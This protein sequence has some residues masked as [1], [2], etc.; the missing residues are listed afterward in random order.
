MVKSYLRYSQGAC[1]G[2]ITSGGSNVQF[3]GSGALGIAPALADV[4]VW[5]LKTGAH[6]TTLHDKNVQAEVT[7]LCRSP[8]GKRVA[9]GYD[10]GSIRLWELGTSKCEAI[11]HGH[12]KSVTVLKYNE[13]GNLLASGSKDTDIVVWDVIAEAGQCRLRGHKDAITDLIFLDRGM[14][15]LVFSCS[16]DTLAKVWEL[17][18][19]QCIQTLVG[20]RNEIWSVDANSE[21]TRIVTAGKDAEIRVWTWDDSKAA[22]TGSTPPELICL[23]SLQRTSR[24]RVVTVRF[25]RLNID[26]LAVQSADKTVEIFKGRDAQQVTKKVKRKLKRKRE[27]EKAKQARSGGSDGTEMDEDDAEASGP[28]D[29]GPSDV[30]TPEDEFAQL[31][32]IRVDAKLRSIDWSPKT[33]RK[34][35]ASSQ[36]L[37]LLLGMSNNSM[38]VYDVD[39]AAKEASR[40]GGVQIAGHRTDV[41]AVSLSSDD[42]MLLSTSNEDVKIWNL[43]SQECIRTISTGYALCGMFLPG[44]RQI[45]IG[46]K[47]GQL[48]L[49]D[50]GSSALL[51]K[52][53][54]HAGAV[55]T[56][57]AKPAGP[58]GI[59]RTI[60]SGS[61]DHD[62]KFWDI[63]LTLDPEWSA[64]TKRV[65]LECAKTLTMTD[66]ILA[67]KYSPDARLLAVALLD[68]TVKIFYEDSLKFFVSL[69]GHKLPVMA[70]DIS[71]DS[72]L[73]VTGSA[74]KNIKIWGLDFGDCHKSMFA[75]QESVMS[76]AFVPRTH[77]FFSAGKDKMVK[78]WDADKFE[79]IL[80]I[81]GHHG[82]VWSVCISSGGTFLVSGSHDRSI[83]VWDQTDEQV[84][85]EEE[86][87]K[88]LEDVF[89]ADLELAPDGADVSDAT[90]TTQRTVENLKAGERLAEA[91][92]LAELD[93][94]AAA[95]K[96]EAGETHK[97]NPL[98][99]GMSGSHYLLRV[100]RQIPAADTEEALLVI[101][102][103]S[104]LTLFKYFDIWL[105]EGTQIEL[106]TRCLF[107][108]LRVYH[109]QLTA[110][111]MR[112]HA[113]LIESLIK[114]T[115]DRVRLEKNT[116]GFN[117]AGLHHVQQEME[118]EGMRFFD[119]VTAIKDA[120]SRGSTPYEKKKRLV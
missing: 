19:R 72:R 44:D 96:A 104:M 94:E 67:M 113:G 98:L 7:A 109:N 12:K 65:T 111:R 36:V 99:L 31:C 34:A 106:T 42:E 49:Y 37:P 54:A 15:P 3:D 110:T 118:E 112:S 14:F 78:Y 86:R 25:D 48:E 10:D 30:P 4:R 95:I 107:F 61:A 92:T 70:L 82:E 74:D 28:S 102:F 89:D 60:A 43:R 97:P 91:L 75:H 62:V 24:S 58:A 47:S 56:L 73:I 90:R 116:I 80:A 50:L 5:N 27:K 101:P 59:V 71:F 51:E 6:V 93:T 23:G 16:K 13:S 46:T 81:P 68:C 87:E 18:S 11:F 52:I 1:L 32:V 38:V 114:N 79:Q 45:L 108:A 64:T 84:F 83:R 55:W 17:D 120:R 85:L 39:V 53:D 33:R 57:A 20:H 2:V 66:D 8:D 29:D 105:K 26:L 40:V 76:L 88:E 77:Y 35:G 115:R 21:Q 103:A 69:Y 9:A 22:D 117:I 41:R 100:L 119:D 63:E